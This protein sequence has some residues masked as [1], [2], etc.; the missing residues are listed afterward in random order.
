MCGHMCLTL[1]W[2]GGSPG[3]VGG[4]LLLAPLSGLLVQFVED[5]AALLLDRIPLDHL[6]L[7]LLLELLLRRR[8]LAAVGV[9]HAAVVDDGRLGGQLVRLRERRLAHV[10]HERLLLLSDGLEHDAH[11]GLALLQHLHHVVVGE[12]VRRLPLELDAL[13]PLGQVLHARLDRDHH[14]REP[15]M[16][17]PLPLQLVPLGAVARLAGG[18]LRLAARGVL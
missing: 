18:G 11:L 2:T 9:A 17:V 5:G 14:A 8:L 1:S 7:H 4:L 12:H 3:S 6:I 16:L 13:E 15:L 10:A